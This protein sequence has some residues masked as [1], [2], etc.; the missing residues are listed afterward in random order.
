MRE[1]WKLGP[2]QLRQIVYETTKI[3]KDVDVMLAEAKE[4]QPKPYV[5]WEVYAGMGRITQKVSELKKQALN[6]KAEKFILATGWDFSKRSD[7]LNQLLRKFRDEEPDEVFLTSYGV[8]CFEKC[9]G[10]RMADCEATAEP[11]TWKSYRRAHIEHKLN[12]WPTRLDQR[13]LGLE[14]ENDDGVILPVKMPTCIYTAPSGR[15]IQ[16]CHSF[17]AMEVII[18]H[19]VDKDLLPDWL[20]I[21]RGTW[22]RWL[23][24]FWLTARRMKT[25]S[26]R[27]KIKVTT[28][29]I[30]NQQIAV[31]CVLSTGPMWQPPRTKGRRLNAWSLE[32]WSRRLA[33]SWDGR[34]VNVN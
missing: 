18:I 32:A 16:R 15:C 20:G 1:V 14:L 3:G 23:R 25:R 31:H 2:H 4:P 34:A 21:T 10:A 29:M 8:R 26:W 5:I 22:R 27:P 30:L 12:G 17:N 6:V 11:W 28:K 13:T 19:H 7:Q 9:W 24:R 33:L